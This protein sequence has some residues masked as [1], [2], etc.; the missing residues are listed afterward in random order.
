MRYLKYYA[1][2]KLALQRLCMMGLL[3]LATACEKEDL[4]EGKL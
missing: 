2:W 4:G 1:G 3:L